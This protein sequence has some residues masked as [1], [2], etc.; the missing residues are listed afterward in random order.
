[1]SIVERDDQTNH[2]N[3]DTPALELR[4]LAFSYPDR[5]DVLKSIDLQVEPGQRVG[6]IGPNGAGKTTLFMLTCGVL[7]PAE[8]EVRLFGEPIKPGA[9]RHEIGMVFQIPGDQ[10]FSPS[11]QDDIAFGPRNLDLSPEEVD[12][13][14]REA[15]RITGT[16]SFLDRPPHHLSGGEK[17][18]VAIA[19]V[20][21]MHPKLV[22]YDEPSANLDI[23]ARRRLIQFLESSTETAL[24]ASHDLELVLEVCDRVVLL[25][26]GGVVAD[27]TPADVMGDPLLMETH[28]LE[29]PHSLLP[30]TMP[31][32]VRQRR[33]QEG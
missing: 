28:G 31:H 6:I 8:G 12:D 21:A 14:V 10:L 25:D 22:I 7:S 24:I 33:Y 13:R 19:G 5:P 23:R 29:T 17:R 4:D 3:K 11:V 27:G 20:L 2:T 1:M 16:E 18:M 15:V 26:G 30:H 9:F 32:H